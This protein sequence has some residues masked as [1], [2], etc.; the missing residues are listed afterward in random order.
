MNIFFKSLRS[1]FIILITLVMAITAGGVI[2]F[3]FKDVG[4]AM[5]EQQS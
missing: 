1:K 2:Y 4:G 5:M 3:T